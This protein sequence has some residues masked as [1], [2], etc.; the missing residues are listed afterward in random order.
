M[1]MKKQPLPAPQATT[2]FLSSVKENLEQ[3]M[4]YRQPPIEPLEDTA[5]LADVVAKLNEFMAR[6]QR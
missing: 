6:V 5:T 2:M 1:T 3:I 4:G